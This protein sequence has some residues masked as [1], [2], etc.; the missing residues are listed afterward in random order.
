M[1][2]Y[3]IF[4]RLYQIE[5]PWNLDHH[6]E[7]YMLQL[8]AARVF[9]ILSE[10]AR[11]NKIYLQSFIKGQLKFRTSRSDGES[12]KD[13]GYPCFDRLWAST[14]PLASNVQLRVDGVLRLRVKL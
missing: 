6:T 5:T 10:P 14:C 9:M 4:K 12:T 8:P 2:R 7:E 3:S 1:S 13:L 11:K